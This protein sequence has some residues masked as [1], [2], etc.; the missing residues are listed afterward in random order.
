MFAQPQR[1]WIRSVSVPPARN[2]G[3]GIGRKGATVASWPADVTGRLTP[4]RS[5]GRTGAAGLALLGE[6]GT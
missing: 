4:G 5:P 1:G 3:P 6:R 2:I